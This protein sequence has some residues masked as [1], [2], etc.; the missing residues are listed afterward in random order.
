MF[1]SKQTALPWRFKIIH[2]PG[3]KIKTSDAT[4]HNYPASKLN[5]LPQE[6]LQD[7]H[8]DQFNILHDEWTQKSSSL[9]KNL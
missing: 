1:C 8:H 4:F 9:S 2:V 7:T 6:W 3:H 5:Q